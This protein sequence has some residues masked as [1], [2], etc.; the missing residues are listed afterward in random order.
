[1]WRA[2]LWFVQVAVVIAAALWLVDRPGDVAINWLG[3]RI[4]T[5]IG[6]LVL[7]VVVVAVVAALLYRLWRGIRRAP[8][9]LGA[10]R[11]SSRR[12]RGYK[13]LTLGMVAVAA[14]EP[15]EARH[16]SKRA[17]EL[18]DEPP[19]TMLLA[20]QSAQLDGDEEAA[21]RYFK[22]MLKHPETEFLGLRGL[23]T[24]ALRRGE[25]ARALELTQRAYRLRPATQWVLQNLFELNA[26]L[27]HYEAAD[28]ALLEAARRKVMPRGQ[29]Q[30]R[31]AVILVERARRAQAGGDRDAALSH[32]R[33][34]HKLAPE[35]EPAV[36]TLARLWID[37]GS[38]GKASRIIER[39]WAA[40]PHPELAA[41]FCEAKEATTP[42]ERVRVLGR[43]APLNANDRT[44][45]MVQAE[46]AIEAEL[47]GEA[48]R[49]L[50]NLVEHAPSERAYRLLAEVEER[51]RGD[52]SAAR[53]W[54]RR[55]TGAPDDFAWTCAA[56]AATQP[57]WSAICNTCGAF[58]SL[59]WREPGHPLAVPSTAAP[60][61]LPAA[62]TPS[63]PAAEQVRRAS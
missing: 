10:M 50:M 7:A 26:R 1:M 24:Q 56:C 41:L 29:A 60:R 34:A 13:S 47:W 17:K 39:A 51:E 58:D 31:R 32:A 14:G 9:S 63:A 22:A 62:T 15:E 2:L 42:L 28:H 36:A 8:R 55:A 11:Q 59:A 3:Y 48:R 52:A 45:H 30:R 4:E 16:Q 37:A 6:V 27:G 40:A 5:S 38:R 49:H 54:L 23:L 12:R 46:A 53:D 35:F 33:E 19:L 57:V 18:L 20:A 21:E 61:A 43:L 25:H 44:T